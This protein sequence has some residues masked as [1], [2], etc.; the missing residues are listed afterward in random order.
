MPFSDNM[1][2][3]LGQYRGDRDDYAFF[4]RRCNQR[5]HL[6]IALSDTPCWRLA[7]IRR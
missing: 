6:Y 1:V 7:P 2:M 5:W 3:L 4:A